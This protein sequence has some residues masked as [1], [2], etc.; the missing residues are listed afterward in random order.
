MIL[1]FTK[2]FM[3]AILG[4][5]MVGVLSGNCIWKGVASCGLGLVVGAIGGAPATGEER[6]VFGVDYLADGIPLVVVGLGIFALP[7]VVDLL[8]G[9]GAIAGTHGL[10]N[11]WLDG[12][13]DMIRYRWLCLR[14]AG[15][16]TLIGAIPGLG[17]SV[18]D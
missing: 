7:E 12:L 11:G 16:G 4:I 13:R 17:G 3:L 15:I 5:S 2:L 1:F 14:C 8:R 9:A 6:L 18:V 10:G